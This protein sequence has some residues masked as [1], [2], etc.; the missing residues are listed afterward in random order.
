MQSLTKKT[1]A[2]A[3]VFIRRT[4]RGGYKTRSGN[5]AP[6]TFD[7]AV[8]VDRQTVAF[9]L[10][11]TSALGIPFALARAVAEKADVT[12]ETFYYQDLGESNYKEVAA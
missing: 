1:E 11:A 7:I 6:D 2:Q 10:A 12:P 5:F 9:D 4:S 8:V 3:E